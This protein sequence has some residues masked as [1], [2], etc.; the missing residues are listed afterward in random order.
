MGVKEVRRRRRWFGGA[1]R[2]GCPGL[3]FM[4]AAQVLTCPLLSL[5]LLHQIT[6][7]DEDLRISRGNRCGRAGFLGSNEQLLD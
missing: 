2:L 5:P 7:V 3:W 6:Y 1:G 4:M